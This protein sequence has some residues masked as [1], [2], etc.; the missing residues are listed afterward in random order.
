MCDEFILMIKC[1]TPIE[2]QVNVCVIKNEQKY[3]CL[4]M[5]GYHKGHMK[6]HRGVSPCCCEVISSEFWGEI[7]RTLVFS[8]LHMLTLFKDLL[9]VYEE[10]FKSTLVVRINL[11]KTIN[12]SAQWQHT[13]CFHSVGSHVWFQNKSPAEANLRLW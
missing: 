8:S 5:D 3:A 13:A 1:K 2:D 9:R 10:I 12:S 6:H 4:F 11:K 7:R